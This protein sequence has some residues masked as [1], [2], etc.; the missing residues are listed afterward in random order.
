MNAEVPSIFNLPTGGRY[1]RVF[2]SFVAWSSALVLVLLIVWPTIS[3]LLFS[4]FG[5]QRGKVQS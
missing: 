4:Q 2:A 3:S 5:F 1:M